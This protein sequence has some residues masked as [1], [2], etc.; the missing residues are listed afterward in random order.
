MDNK[1][2]S[3]WT[4]STIDLLNLQ[5]VVG[6]G[7]NFQIKSHTCLYRRKIFA[8][9]DVDFGILCN[10]PRNIRAFFLGWGGGG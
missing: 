1:F 3:K 2:I 5:T 8:D 7:I 4:D 6:H 10:F 9:F